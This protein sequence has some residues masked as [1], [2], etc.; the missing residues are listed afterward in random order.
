MVTKPRV[1]KGKA[2]ARHGVNTSGT[3][4]MKKKTQGPV[5]ASKLNAGNNM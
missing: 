1:E 3:K 5:Q 2:V 4:A